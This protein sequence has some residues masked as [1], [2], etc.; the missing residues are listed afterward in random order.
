MSTTSKKR[1]ASSSDAADHD[2]K[3]I[4]GVPGIANTLAPLNKHSRKEGNKCTAT[5]VCNVKV[6]HLRPKYKDL[7]EWCKEEGNLYIG[8]QG[9]VFIDKQRYPKTQSIWANP[10]KVGRDGPLP[11][12]IE[13][14][15]KHIREMIASDPKT[16]DVETLRGHNLGC[17]C[18]SGVLSEHSTKVPVVCH[19]QVLMKIM[20]E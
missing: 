18:V 10:F 2:N 3:D 15:E 9:V 11:K 14:F 1:K 17:W 8:R 6:E 7:R 19:G 12:V 4:S 16:F 13:K 20:N 5:T